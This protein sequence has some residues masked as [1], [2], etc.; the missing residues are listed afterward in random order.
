[1]L[2]ICDMFEKDKVFSFVEGL[3]P[4]MKTKFYE[5]RVQN[6]FKAYSVVERLFDLSKT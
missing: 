2:D 1:M 4:W 6:I 5:Q 3:K